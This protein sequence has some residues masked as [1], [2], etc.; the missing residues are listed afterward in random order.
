M[1]VKHQKQKQSFLRIYKA[2][3]MIMKTLL[4]N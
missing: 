2:L 1:I 4:D 3:I